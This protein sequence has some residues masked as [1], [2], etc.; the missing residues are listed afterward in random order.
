[1]FTTTFATLPT[2]SE[3]ISG[4]SAYSGDFFTA[5]L[6]FVEFAVGVFVGCFII[7]FMYKLVVENVWKIINHTSLGHKMSH[8]P[9]VPALDRWSFRNSSAGKRFFGN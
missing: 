7:Y 4:L 8:L 5:F 6:P 1:M 9:G 2:G 3:M